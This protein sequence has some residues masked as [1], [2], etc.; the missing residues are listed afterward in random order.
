MRILH[1]SAHHAGESGPGTR[2]PAAPRLRRSASWAPRPTPPTTRHW[3]ASQRLVSREPAFHSG[4]C[5]RVFPAPRAQAE[6]GIRGGFGCRV[7]SE[8]LLERR[9]RVPLHVVAT[10][11]PERPAAPPGGREAGGA[12][13]RGRLPAPGGGDQGSTRSRA[14]RQLRR[15]QERLQ[16]QE[17]RRVREVEGPSSGPG[18]EQRWRVGPVLTV[19]GV[20]SPSTPGAPALAL[21]VHSRP[22]GALGGAQDLGTADSGRQVRAE[23]RPPGQTGGLT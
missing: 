20:S 4:A 7:F 18:G 11:P 10:L 12:G 3:T 9:P 21:R 2:E 17:A 16:R 19:L 5:C 14:L 6:R 15:E 23:C 22:R 1:W 8:Q 13:P